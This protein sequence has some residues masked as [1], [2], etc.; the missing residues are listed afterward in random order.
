[1]RYIIVIFLIVISSIFFISFNGSLPITD[2]VESNYALTAKEMLISGNYLSPQIYGNYWFDKPILIYGLI[3]LS[4]KLFGVGEFAARFPAAIFSVFSVLFT[5]WFAGQVY[6]NKYSAFLA[7]IILATS[8]EFWILSKAIIT[9]AV[10]FFFTS[11]SLG[12]LYVAIIRN[13]NYCYI[14]AY[15]AAGLA[16]LTKGPVGIVL[17]CLIVFSYIFLTR[18]WHYLSKLYLLKG[19]MVFLIVTVPWY[20]YMYLLHGQVFIDGF[21]GLHNYMRATVSEHPEDNVFYYYLLVY[22][23]SIMPWVGVLL[24]FIKNIKEQIKVPHNTYF[25]MWILVTIVFY[26]LM[27]TKYSTY[28]FPVLFPTALLLGNFI[29]N[30]NY[31]SNIKR[32]GLPGIVFSIPTVLLFALFGI[33]AYIRDLGSLPLYLIVCMASIIV[34]WVNIKGDYRKFTEIVALLTMIVSISLVGFGLPGFMNERSAKQVSNFIEKEDVSVAIYGNYSTSFV[35]YTDTLATHLSGTKEKKERDEAWNTKN[36]MPTE[37]KEQF[38]QRAKTTKNAYILV[39]V[40]D[41]SKINTDPVFEG[42][43][44]INTSGDL[45]LFQRK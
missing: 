28:I 7:A 14:I 38:I 45:M 40:K 6:R 13:K 20:L 42:Y 21:L 26:S 27:A 10:L 19:I 4:Y 41:K 12:T 31:D 32:S 43:N 23:L 16:V 1:M 5:Y 3:I 29:A 37:S 22:P 30:I 33:A 18:R 11:V 36:P 15:A 44:L 17:P 34:I 39:D 35:F 2:P 24:L 9:D 25:I 8:L